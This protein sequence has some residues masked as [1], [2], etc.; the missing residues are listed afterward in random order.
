MRVVSRMVLGVGLV[1]WGLATACAQ[2]F[3]SHAVK[4]VVPFVPGGGIDV[5]VRAL[6][7]ELAQRWGQAVY[8]DNRAGAG[9]LIGAQAVAQAPADGYT[10]LATIDQTMVANRF[11]YKT[12]PYD[13]ERDFAPVSLLARSDHLLV[14]NAHFAPNTIAELIAYSRK[15]PGKVAYGSF[16]QGSQPHLV[17]ELLNKR[18]RLDLIHVPYKGVA[19]VMAALIGGEVQ[20][21]TASAAVAGELIKAGKLK[22]I[23][24]A[25]K[26]RA[27]QF[28]AVSTT[29]EQGHPEL[30]ASI[31]YGLFVPAGTP[32]SVV[33]RIGDDVR[34]IVRDPAF[35][36]RHFT[37]KGLEVV[38]STPQELHDAIAADVAATA[39]MVRAADVH[40]E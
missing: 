18:E 4:I 17:Y 36:E 10:L 20:L 16:G 30:V 13:P 29:A 7:S 1:L 39:D 3:P 11:L 35:R 21:S 24:S 26:Q 19:P 12:L 25:G 9:S 33:A 14:A 8:V 15:Y 6:A 27:S 37:S 28:P 22:V 34:A 5:V 23:A 31:W 2:P 32:G 38:M 40:P